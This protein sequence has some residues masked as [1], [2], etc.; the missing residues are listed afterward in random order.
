MLAPLGH[1]ISLQQEKGM[2]GSES[3]HTVN[4]NKISQRDRISTT[5]Y[6]KEIETDTLGSQASYPTSLCLSFPIWKTGTMIVTIS[7]GC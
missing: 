2:I 6:C 1:N 4:V 5:R 3:L 7:T